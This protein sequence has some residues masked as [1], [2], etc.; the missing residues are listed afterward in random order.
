MSGIPIFGKQVQHMFNI[1]N[2]VHMPVDVNITIIHIHRT[3]RHT[4]AHFD[5][6]GL[7]YRTSLFRL[8]I[9]HDVTAV[10]RQQVG[11]FAGI[12]IDHGPHGTRITVNLP[13]LPVNGKVTVGKQTVHVLHPRIYREFL[14][15]SRHIFQFDGQA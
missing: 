2:T 4:T 6:T 1:F 8:Y 10:Q 3:Y 12:H 15:L 11:R 7:L 14:I 9:G 5:T 13:V